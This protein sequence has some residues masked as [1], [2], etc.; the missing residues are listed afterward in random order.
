MFPT[1]IGR[2]IIKGRDNL[3]NAISILSFNLSSKSNSYKYFNIPEKNKTK[4]NTTKNKKLFMISLPK[5][6]T[7]FTKLKFHIF[8]NIEELNWGYITFI[9]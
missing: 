3:F 7:L 6:T 1:R 8:I 4:Q 5:R 9:K 2:M